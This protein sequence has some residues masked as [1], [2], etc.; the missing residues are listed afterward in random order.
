[1]VMEK[2]SYISRKVKCVEN[3]SG[4]HFQDLPLNNDCTNIFEYLFSLTGECMKY[5]S[6]S[7]LFRIRYLW[8]SHFA[9]PIKRSLPPRAA[10]NVVVESEAILHRQIFSS[11]PLDFIKQRARANLKINT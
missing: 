9:S 1:M 11:A 4:S 8:S 5:I 10:D 2:I 7:P 6:T 3:A